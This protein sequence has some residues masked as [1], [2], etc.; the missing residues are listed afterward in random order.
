MDQNHGGP[1]F[2]K[3]IAYINFYLIKPHFDNFFQHRHGIC[4]VQTWNQ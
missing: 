2:L 3:N 1:E 4:I